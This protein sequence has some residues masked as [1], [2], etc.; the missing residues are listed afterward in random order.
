MTCYR[1][2]RNLFIVLL[3]LDELGLI[4]IFISSPA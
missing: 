2:R 4:L 3:I 1:R